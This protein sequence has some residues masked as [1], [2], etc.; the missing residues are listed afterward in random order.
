MIMK[1][2]IIV[3]TFNSKLHDFSHPL[4]I[5]IPVKIFPSFRYTKIKI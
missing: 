4:H 5:F 1:I 3:I 2:T